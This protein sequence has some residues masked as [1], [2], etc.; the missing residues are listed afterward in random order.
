MAHPWTP[1]E[2]PPEAPPHSS[3]G[4]TS[5]EETG[6]GRSAARPRSIKPVVVAFAAAALVVFVLVGVAVFGGSTPAD[7]S[8]AMAGPSTSGIAAMLAGLVL[9]LV[10][11]VVAIMVVRGQQA[12]RRRAEEARDRA[13]E[14]AQLLAAAMEPEAAMRLLGYDSTSHPAPH[15]TP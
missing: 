9:L 3:E 6:Y 12:A 2:T 13:M 14:R 4:S 15:Q 10:G 7:G 11:G 5:G 8:E 1:P